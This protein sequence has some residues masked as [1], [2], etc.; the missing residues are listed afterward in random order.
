MSVTSDKQNYEVQICSFLPMNHAVC[1]T[2]FYIANKGSFAN[3]VINSVPFSM[4]QLSLIERDICP[5]NYQSSIN[6][7][8]IYMRY[9]NGDRTLIT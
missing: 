2:L 5:I 3:K 6:R 7:Q 1:L 8:F 4:I 9:C